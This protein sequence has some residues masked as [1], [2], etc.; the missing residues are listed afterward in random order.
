MFYHSANAIATRE[1]LQDALNSYYNE[2]K[3]DEDLWLRV[4]KDLEIAL[5]TNGR[6]FGGIQQ[7]VIWDKNVGD[8]MSHPRK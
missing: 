4:R 8:G 2:G 6:S 7:I 5:A 1:L 3:K